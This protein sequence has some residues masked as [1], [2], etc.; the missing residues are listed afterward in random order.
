MDPFG[1]WIVRE[2]R[3]LHLAHTDHFLMCGTAAFDYEHC[4]RQDEHYKEAKD[5][6]DNEST[7]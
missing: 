5:W 7:T 1:D 2:F 4:P 3:I 6:L